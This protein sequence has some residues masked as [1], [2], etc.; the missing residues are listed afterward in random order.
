MLSWPLPQTL[1][2]LR[3]FLGLVGYYRRFIPKFGIVTKPLIEMLKKDSFVWSTAATL[4][5]QHLKQLLSSTS[6]LA[7]P[8]YSKEFMVEVDASGFGIGAVLMQDSHPIAYISR[9]L[10]KQQQSLSTYEKEL[11]VV[12]FAVHKQKHCLLPNHFVIKTDHSSLKYILEQKL[13]MVFPQKWLVKLME[14]D[15]SI[16]YRQGKENVVV[17]VLS[18]VELVEC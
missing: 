15:F 11:L 2:Q 14:F 6:A 7:L 9:T 5:F 8:N 16:Q 18:R 17:D 1:K 13:S 3:G 12:V 10:N 4:A